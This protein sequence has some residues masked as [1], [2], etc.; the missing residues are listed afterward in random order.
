MLRDPRWQKK[1][2][3]VMEL[4][5]FTCEDCGTDTETLNVHHSYYEKGLAPWDYP[6]QSLHCLCDDCH[7]KAEDHKVAI[8]RKMGALDLTRDTEILGY[9]SAIEMS[10]LPMVVCE[11]IDWEMAEGI[12]HYFNIDP[13]EIIDALVDRQ[14]DG[15]KLEEIAKRHRGT[16]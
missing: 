2:L 13:H 7:K 15:Y 6:D 4:V 8:H 3:K 1:R 9:L 12:G 10:D 11:V 5:N 16:K 14:I